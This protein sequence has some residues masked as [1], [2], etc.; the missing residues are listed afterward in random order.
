MTKQSFP[1]IQLYFSKLGL[2][3]CRAAIAQVLRSAAAATGG[4]RSSNAGSCCVAVVKSGFFFRTS[5]AQ[6]HLVPDYAELVLWIIGN[7][8]L[9]FY[10]DENVC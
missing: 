7:Y 1:R 2:F 6:H 3:S 4:V 8:I 10:S 5:Y 9:F